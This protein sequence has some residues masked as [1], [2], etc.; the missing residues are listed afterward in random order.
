MNKSRFSKVSHTDLVLPDDTP[1]E[2]IGGIRINATGIIVAP[3][4]LA[5][6][7]S[8][9]WQKSVELAAKLDFGGHQWRAPEVEEAFL[10]PDRSRFAPAVDPQFFPFLSK[11][12]WIWT[13]TADASDLESFAWGVGLCRGGSLLS[14]QADHG[15]ALAVRGPV[16]VPG[17]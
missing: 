3:F 9:P 1:I 7:R 4:L 14:A 2:E 17:Q 10:I 8:V 11:G 6:G 15:L 13:A 16:A 5:D 12:G